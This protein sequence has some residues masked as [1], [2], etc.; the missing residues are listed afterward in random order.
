MPR[1]IF[2]LRLAAPDEARAVAEVIQEAARWITTWRSPLWDPELVGL[3]FVTPIIGLGQMLT[4][5]TGGEIAGVMILLPADPH[6]WP[7][8]APGEA[9]YLH[10]LAVRRAYA[11]MGLPA[12]LMDYT[13]GLAR[14]QG[15]RFLRLDCDPPLAAFYER[16]GFH[17]VDEIDVHHPEAGPMRVA[18]MERGPTA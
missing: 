1:Q 7:D 2:D 18:R 17:R 16:L 6:F 3:A 12:M 8:D 15:R 4:A 11:G 14:A 5:R 10:K 9:L 13:E